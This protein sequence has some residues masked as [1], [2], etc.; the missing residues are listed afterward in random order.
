MGDVLTF[1]EKR[2]RRGVISLLPGE[3][4]CGKKRAHARLRGSCGSGQLQQPAQPVPAFGEILANLP[5]AKQGGAQ[6]Q[7]PLRVS[8]LCQP[9]QSGAKIV[10]LEPEAFQ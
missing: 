6:T 8:S 7:S 10:V 4:A 5:K 9:L 1:L 3:H 2:I